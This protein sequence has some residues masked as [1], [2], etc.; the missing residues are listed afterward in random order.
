MTFN[1]ENPFAHRSTLEY[2]LPDF[3]KIRTE[4]YLPAFYA[5]CEQHL[6]EVAAILESGE[7]TFENTLVELERSGKLLERMLVVFYTKSSS[8]T[9]DEIDKIEEEIA[10]KLAAHQDAIQLNPALYARVEELYNKRESLG[11][12]AESDWLL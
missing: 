10:P 4:H 2:E 7:P 5:G 3:T 12:D 8:D 9:N 1:D 6:A 11:L